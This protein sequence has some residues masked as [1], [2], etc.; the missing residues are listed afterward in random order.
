MI[1]FSLGSAA[2]AG[3]FQ[4][5]LRQ[6]MARFLAGIYCEGKM[7]KILLH[8]LGFAAMHKRI[9]YSTTK[10]FYTFSGRMV[11]TAGDEKDH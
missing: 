4:L 8:T 2:M 6:D 10:V 7:R 9:N 11:C 1:E 3:L 5:F